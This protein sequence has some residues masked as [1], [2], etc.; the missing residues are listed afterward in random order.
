MKRYIAAILIPC[1][2]LQL[3]GCYS[4]RIVE[5]PEPG[6]NIK[7]YTKNYKVIEPKNWRYEDGNI[8]GFMGEEKLEGYTAVKVET[9]MEQK[10]INK[11]EE[12]YL[13]ITN[14][15]I[16][17]GGIVIVGL[18]ILYVIFAVEANEEMVKEV[19]EL[20]NN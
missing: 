20:L 9:K 2:L 10:E 15:S 16:L 5:T 14:T 3:C 19:G 7:I 18:L 1:F 8:V 11:I 12:E 17:I 4:W 13:N 6:S